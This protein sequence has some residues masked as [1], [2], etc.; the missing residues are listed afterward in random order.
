M[1]ICS[2]SALCLRLRRAC[3]RIHSPD[4]AIPAVHPCPR[5]KQRSTCASGRACHLP[6]TVP[7]AQRHCISAGCVRK[8][9]RRTPPLRVNCADDAVIAVPPHRLLLS[10]C[11]A[12][13]AEPQHA[14]RRAPLLPSPLCLR[15]KFAATAAAPRRRSTYSSQQRTLRAG[16]P[17][18]GSSPAVQSCCAPHPLLTPR[19]AKPRAGPSAGPLTPKIR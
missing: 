12:R 9:R 17:T 4:A 2:R 19:L 10:A 16:P 18:S 5:L 11:G 6:P 15:A 13:R 1:I 3:R 8:A 7:T 14:C